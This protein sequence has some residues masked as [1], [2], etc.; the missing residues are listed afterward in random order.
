M[1][2]DADGS[3]NPK[4]MK[5]LWEKRELWDVVI[6]SRYVRGGSTQ[7]PAILIAMS[8]VLNCAYQ[9]AFNLPARDVSNSFRLYRGDQ[10]RALELSSPDFDIVEEILIRL[11]CGSAKARVTEVPVMFEK[12]KAGESKRNL[13]AFVFSYLKSIRTLR[14][15]RATE[16]SKAAGGE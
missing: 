12:R 1:L 16:L 9:F 11:V 14:R 4:D 2:M 7:N 15:F 8:R 6:G 10:L 5:R 13:T 3:H